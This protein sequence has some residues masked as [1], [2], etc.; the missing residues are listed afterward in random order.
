MQWIYAKFGKFI[1]DW[2]W[3]GIRNT[4]YGLSYKWKPELLK[5]REG[6]LYRDLKM[7]K[8]EHGNTRV[9]RL[10]GPDETYVETVKT[11][12][13]FHVIY[14]YRLGPVYGTM[15]HDIPVRRNNMDGRPILSIRWGA[16]D[17]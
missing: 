3:L 15:I 12:K 14:G 9:I 17:D 8:W 5:L 11:Y 1:G 16:K 7:D 4:A 10:F 6:W 13:F 2:Y